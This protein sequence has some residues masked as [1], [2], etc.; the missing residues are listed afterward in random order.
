MAWLPISNIV[1]QYTNP[2]TGLPYSGAV[3]KAYAVGTTTNIPFAVDAAATATENSIALNASGYPEVSGNVVIPHLNQ[4]YKL[5]L[6][7]TQTAANADSGAA[8]TVDNITLPGLTEAATTTT[9]EVN[10]SPTED[11]GG[12]YFDGS[13]DYLTREAG[14]TDAADGKKGTLVAWVTFDATASAVEYILANTGL[15]L[16]LRR[17]ADGTIELL[18][19]NSGGSVILDISTVEAYNDTDT[20]YCIMASWDLGTPGSQFLYVNDVSD[21]AT[22]TFTND[23]IDYTVANWAVGADVSGTNK[24]AGN[25]HSLWLDTTSNLDLSIEANRR[26]FRDDSGVPVALGQGGQIPLGSQVILYLQNPYT[27]FQYNRGTG[28]DFT[29]T[30]TLATPTVTKRAG[31]VQH[32]LPGY[33]FI[34]SGTE[35]AVANLIIRD[36]KTRYRAYLFYF[37]SLLPATDATDLLFRL[38]VDNAANFLTGASDYAWAITAASEAGANSAAGDDADS[39][40]TIAVSCGSNSTEAIAGCIEIYGP[41]ENSITHITHRHGRQSS[42]PV[43]SYFAGAGQAQA[44]AVHNAFSLFFSSGNIASMNWTLIGVRA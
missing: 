1:P 32:L 24:L 4:N 22:T 8:W 5:A 21:L 7:P 15:A 30:G 12:A 31:T 18:A 3:L 43:Y 17:N 9:G 6:Y 25:I 35:A 29:V 28:G 36:L 10:V 20:S 26:R 27:A 38:S 40:I 33:E 37:D 41:A 23:T 2:A 14:L 13:N 39:E 34:A 19:E 42:A 11:M 16:A 44:A